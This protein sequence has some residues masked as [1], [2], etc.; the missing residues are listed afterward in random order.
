MT[1]ITKLINALKDGAKTKTEI[2][3]F[4]GFKSHVKHVV[5]RARKKGY[6]IRFSSGKYTLEIHEKH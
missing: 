3:P 1:E 5:D 2:E 6:L 4:L